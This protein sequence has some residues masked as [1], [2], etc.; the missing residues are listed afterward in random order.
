MVL[1]QRSKGDLKKQNPTYPAPCEEKN[2]PTEQ[3]PLLVTCCDRLERRTVT[4]Q[5]YPEWS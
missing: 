3:R 5:K 2:D 1:K 4:T